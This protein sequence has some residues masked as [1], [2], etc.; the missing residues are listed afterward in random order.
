M[1]G[2]VLDNKPLL[3]TN[4]FLQ[5]DPRHCMYLGLSGFQ[6]MNIVDGIFLMLEIMLYCDGY[7]IY[8]NENAQESFCT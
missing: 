5:A 6:C 4:T 1:N 2:Y 8:S 3:L 7:K